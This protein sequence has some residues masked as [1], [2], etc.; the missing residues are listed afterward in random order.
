MA[1][2]M[3]LDLGALVKGLFSK[4]QKGGKGKKAQSPYLS[5]I[6][7]GVVIFLS[8]IA[9]VFLVYLPDQKEIQESSYGQHWRPGIETVLISGSHDCPIMKIAAVLAKVSDFQFDEGHSKASFQKKSF[10]F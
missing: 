6:I 4:D 10:L 3:N 9:Y 7:I 8:V 5:S 2:D 1:I